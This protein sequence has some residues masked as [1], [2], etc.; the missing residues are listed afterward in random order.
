MKKYHS[1]LPYLFGV[2]FIIFQGCSKKDFVISPI[3]TAT[4]CPNVRFSIT[5]IRGTT[6]M[7][8]FSVSF[9]GEKPIIFRNG[10]TIESIGVKGLSAILKG[11]YLNSENNIL[12][13]AFSGAPD[14]TGNAVFLLH[15]DKQSCEIT[16]PIKK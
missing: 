5:L 6:Y 4:P 8:T 1:W 10:N 3:T 11:D 16:I 13:Y 2:I 9:K 12:T 7:G 15:F 14:T